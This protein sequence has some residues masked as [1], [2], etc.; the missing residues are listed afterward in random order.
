MYTS[1]IENQIVGNTL[2]PLLRIIPLQ[3]QCLEIIDRVYD[4]P[5]Y[6]PIPQ[7]DI[8]EIEVNIRNNASDL[9]SFEF[10]C[11]IVKL[12]FKKLF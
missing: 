3:G 7:K 1:I 11:I 2:A 5:H 8:T 4:S 12:H 6:C 9:V 10:G